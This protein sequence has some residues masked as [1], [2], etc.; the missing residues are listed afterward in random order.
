MDLQDLLYTNKF[1]SSDTLREEEETKNYGVFQKYMTQN[2]HPTQYY[3]QNRTF[4]DNPVNIQRNI[5]QKWPVLQ[6]KNVY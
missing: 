5:S 4:E 2:N 6:N 1:V 3:L